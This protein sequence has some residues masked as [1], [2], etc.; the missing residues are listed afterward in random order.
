M[1]IKADMYAAGGGVTVDSV[2]AFNLSTTGSGAIS[3]PTTKKAKG[4]VMHYVN[5]NTYYELIA[6]DGSNSN[7]PFWPY[8]T[9]YDD[10]VVT[11]NDTSI[12]IS[13]N[14]GNVAWSGFILY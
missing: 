6:I 10:A 12:S 2:S 8:N 11:Y 7:H 1:L 14:P 4:I 5:G 13:K 3:I 9:F